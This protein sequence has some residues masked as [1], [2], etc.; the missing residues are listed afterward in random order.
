MK[1][2]AFL[3]TLLSLNAFAAE[4]LVSHSV[5]PF[6]R[7]YVEARFEI[8]RTQGRAWVNIVVHSTRHPNHDRQSSEWKKK[9]DGLSFDPMTNSI[10]FNGTVCATVRRNTITNTGCKFSSKELTQEYDDGYN[11]P[12]K[13]QMLQV[14]LI[15]E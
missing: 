1:C 9:V 8:N 5:A 6:Q 15:S 10:V 12:I 7:N 11:R 4:T 14:Y 13:Y 3:F 2:L